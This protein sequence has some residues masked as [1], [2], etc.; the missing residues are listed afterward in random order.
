LE[1]GHILLF[2]VFRPNMLTFVYA[3][4]D[5]APVKMLVLKNP[6]RIFGTPKIFRRFSTF[7]QIL[8]I[9]VLSTISLLKISC[10]VSVAELYFTA[11]VFQH[12]LLPT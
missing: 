2:A 5:L 11:D 9:V 7:H 6:Q 10:V 12:S 3:V 4:H 8:S 1:I